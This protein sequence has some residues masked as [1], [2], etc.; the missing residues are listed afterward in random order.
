MYVLLDFHP[1]LSE[2]MHVRLLKD[3]CQDHDRT[4]RTI[5]LLSHEI[6]CRASSITSPRAS[7]SLSRGRFDEIFFVDLPRPAVR[8]DILRIHANR[9]SVKLTDAEIAQLAQAC[10]GFSGAE[11]EQA[12]VSAVYAAHADGEAI[13]AARVLKECRRRGHRRS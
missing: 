7:V 5:V 12:V 10:E 2:P 6:P 8:A 1:F 11:I 4:P 3:I 9:R 13:G